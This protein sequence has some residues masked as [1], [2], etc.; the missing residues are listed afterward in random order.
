MYPAFF[1]LLR[2]GLYSL[3]WP[4]LPPFFFSLFGPLQLFCCDLWF[5]TPPRGRC[6]CCGN[7]LRLDGNSSRLFFSHQTFKFFLGHEITDSVTHLP[8]ITQYFLTEQFTNKG[9]SHL[10]DQGQ[11]KSQKPPFLCYN[12]PSCVEG[13]SSVEERIDQFLV[14]YQLLNLFPRQWIF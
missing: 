2:N 9:C 13:N 11:K 5:R 4:L 12:S 10:R 3:F 7:L 14:S 1:L 6:P 8:P